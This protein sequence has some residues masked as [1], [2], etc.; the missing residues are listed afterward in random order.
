M[1]KPG[2]LVIAIVPARN[3]R[4]VGETVSALLSTNRV[5]RVVVV[6]DG[7]TDDTAERARSAGATVLVLPS[8]VGKG[9]ALTAAVAEF[10][11]AEV[12]LLVDADL[13]E[14]AVHTGELLDPV[15]A[16]VADMVIAS[17]P[18]A[19]G[20]GGFGAIKNASRWLI[21][22]ECGYVATEPLSGQRA[23]RGA[24]LRELSLAP[25]FGVEV[26]MTV[27]AVRSGATILEMPLPLDH[28]HTG[29]TLAGFSHRGAQ[30]VDITR[31]MIARVGTTR[32]RW[33]A[34]AAAV[35]L[36]VVA[37]SISVAGS[38]AT[39]APTLTAKATNAGGGVAPRQ[40]I[41]LATV[42]NTS[43]S[44]IERK[45]LPNISALMAGTGGALTPKIPAAPQD[46][47]SA[48]AS[49]GAGA[50]VSMSGRGSKSSYGSIGALGSALHSAGIT[51][52]YVGARSGEGAGSTPG[53]LAIADVDGAIDHI[54]LG[55]LPA[56]PDETLATA[57]AQRSEAVSTALEHA[58]V[59]LVDLGGSQEPWPSSS[60]RMTSEIRVARHERR[61]D[62][63]RVADAMVG[64]LVADH[65]DAL[66]IV[67]GVSPASH[68]RLTPL[69]ASG[70]ATGILWSPSTRQPGL[71]ALTDIAPTVLSAAGV[72]AP[73]SMIGQR[74]SAGPA[75]SN[76]SAV[77]DL[78]ERT[79][80]REGLTAKLTLAIIGLQ[81][82]MYL[83]TLYGLTRRK[84]ALRVAELVSLACA[85]LPVVSFAYRLA[86]LSM[87]DPL[88]AAL[89]ISA[90]SW[91]LALIARRFRRHP[92]S[93]LVVVAAVTTVV[94]AFDAASSGAL[95][96]VSLL[97][98]T[99]LT[100]ARFYGMGNFGFAVFGSGAIL[101]AGSWVA[102][103]PRR[104]DGAVAA[105][106]LVTSVAVLQITPSMGADFG[107]AL[108][109][110]PVGIAASLAWWGARITK[111]RLAIIAG[112]S[113]VAVIALAVAD[114]MLSDGSHV[115]RFATAG[116]S[117]MW[118]T[119]ERKVAANLH[120]LTS[121]NW[122]W[123][124]LAFVVATAAC[125]AFARGRFGWFTTAPIWR[126]TAQVLAA[127]A[128]LG[129]LLNDSGIAIPAMVSIYGGAL[130][131]MLARRT[132]F[133]APVILEPTPA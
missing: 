14:T 127:F 110:V 84:R 35:V 108:V 29:R 72:G 20:R 124:L 23:V 18:P 77:S 80:L 117:Q 133:T 58:G 51:T 38:S 25:R 34:M 3:S 79:I 43:L 119:I 41:I 44:D 87:Q 81:S 114:S 28:E 68:W 37:A 2:G 63:V 94:M 22:R 26:S 66:V 74:L 125:A 57:V 39:A 106:A 62:Q 8:N 30:A 27:D 49:L 102:S 10:D 85:S 45:V 69:A 16:G 120:M 46:Q 122:S 101:L 6:D 90:A 55:A 48:F 61:L 56:A 113:V 92:L 89:G 93:P 31:G 91:S 96:N 1:N 11:D 15:C 67:V 52:G 112:S 65:P 78:H 19:A 17:F 88:I 60:G 4:R 40:K 130:L 99:P 105:T 121:S 100:A 131:V 9:D 116:V 103:S 12:Y 118:S 123:I 75:P 111:A 42:T 54:E 24:L 97:G 95:Q 126:T 5:D 21:E 115:A 107:G 47:A 109:L 50:P 104:R 70:G 32:Q 86:P 64:S 128:V 33:A 36:V 132:P 71:S 82:I 53:M 59:V 98:Y 73:P 129:G 7:S 83:M 76:L 13:A